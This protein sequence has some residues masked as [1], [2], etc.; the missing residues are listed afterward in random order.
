MKVVYRIDDEE[1]EQGAFA[2]ELWKEQELFGAVQMSNNC[3]PSTLTFNL[4]TQKSGL[5]TDTGFISIDEM[6]A[7]LS[8]V[9]KKGRKKS[10]SKEEV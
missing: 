10:S 5:H 7:N 6:E 4:I 2:L 3:T 9:L 1:V 8:A